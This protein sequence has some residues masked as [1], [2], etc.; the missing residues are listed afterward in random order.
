MSRITAWGN[1]HGV[2]IPREVLEQAD[3]APESEVAMERAAKMFRQLGNP[4]Y[5]QRALVVLAHAYAMSGNVVRAREILVE[6]KALVDTSRN[7]RELGWYW[8]ALGI[9]EALSGKFQESLVAATA[10]VQLARVHADT[11]LENW[12]GTWLVIATWPRRSFDAGAEG[13]EAHSRSASLVGP[14]F[15]VRP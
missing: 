3:I 5:L 10:A 8:C 6:A 13:I 12:A 2:R 7:E 14:P 15:G 1:S 11:N 4:F 9:T